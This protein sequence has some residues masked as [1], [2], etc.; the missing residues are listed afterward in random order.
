MSQTP[1]KSDTVSRSRYE[2]ERAAREHAEHL[3][4]EKSRALYLANEALNKH[5]SQL[6][7]AV[8]DRTAELHAALKK[9]EKDAAIKSRFFA[10][11]NHEIRTPLGGLLG[12][13]DLLAMDEESRSKQELLRNAK[14][15]GL[16]LSRIVND[17]LDFSKMEAGV[18]AFEE[19]EVDLRAL[20]ESVGSVARAD[21]RMAERH[22]LSSVDTS[23][24]KRFFGDA[25][26]IRQ[27]I[28]NFVTNAIRYSH[29]GPVIIRARASGDIGQ[30]TLR[31]EVEDFGVG[32]EEHRIKDLFQD[33]SQVP[34]S[35]TAAAQGTGLGLAISRR[36][37]EG[38]K[39]Q[40]GV[41]T[42][43]GKGSVFWFEIPVRTIHSMVAPKAT[44]PTQGGRP[45]EGLRIL[46]AEDNAINQKLLVTFL[47][48]MGVKVDLAEDGAVALKKFKPHK[49]D[50]LLMDVAMPEV[51]GLEAVRRLRKDWQADQLPPIV[52]LTA[53]EIPVIREDAMTLGAAKVLTKPVQYDTLES[54]ISTIIG[55]GA[56][57]NGNT[58]EGAS[59]ANDEGA[60][61]R[62]S[63]LLSAEA[64][65]SHLMSMSVDELCELVDD[66]VL[67]ALGIV[68]R[69]Q[70]SYDKG[71]L[72]QCSNDAHSLVGSSRI[73]GFD[74]VADQARRIETG[75][76]ELDASQLAILLAG[77]GLSLRQIHDFMK[78]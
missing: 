45:I 35:L 7:H 54:E 9:A 31:V 42:E 41:D 74:E 46:L 34:N 21:S 59:P 32:V 62:L 43:F 44:S 78:V 25:T 48:R 72:D 69:I 60:E 40:I 51:D 1:E 17:V 65:K 70:T 71:D 66:Y 3:L 33:F 49:Y 5:A 8:Q 76:Q 12:M 64:I 52:F 56:Q 13:I 16:A 30:E 20:L 50:L 14:A 19:D 61:S 22:F 28:S 53:H 18:F 11:M 24:P 37:I 47:K 29:N 38:L 15:S 58:L 10:T 27:V 26:R 75:I 4:E 63:K 23:V 36:I 57:A 55:L 68:D 6:E 39:G 2:Q 73:V 67:D 77:I